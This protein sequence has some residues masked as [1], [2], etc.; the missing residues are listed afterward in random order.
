MS[1][2]EPSGPGDVS[3]DRSTEGQDDG[4]PAPKRPWLVSSLIFLGGALVLIGLP[5]DYVRVDEILG[6]TEVLT[7]L[8]IAEKRSWFLAAGIAAVVLAP[9][10]Y[11]L[12]DRQFIWMVLTLVLVVVGA[13]AAV[14]ASEDAEESLDQV[15]LD[16]GFI[17]TAELGSDV[18]FIGAALVTLGASVFA[19]RR[20]VFRSYD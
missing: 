7:A 13:R 4:T 16:E 9:I 18:I 1:D 11:F 12:R 5:L 8:D 15:A 14:I 20:M 2:M 17:L 6:E 3:K 19:I 10:V